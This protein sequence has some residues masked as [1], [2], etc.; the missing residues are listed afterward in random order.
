QLTLIAT[1]GAGARFEQWTGDVQGTSNITTVTMDT[2]KSVAAVFAPLPTITAIRPSAGALRGGDTV[3]IEG[4]RLDDASVVLFSGISLEIIARNSTSITVKTPLS[5]AAS[6]NPEGPVD[7]VVT[8]PLGDAVRLQ[9]F[10][11]MGQPVVGAT[12]PAKASTAGGDRILLRGRNLAIATQVLFG[13]AAGVIDEASREDTRLYVAAPAHAAGLVD[14]ELLSNMDPAVLTGAFL[15]V[16]VPQL[17]SIFPNLGS[18]AGGDIVVISGDGLEQPQSVMFGGVA[19]VVSQASDPEL[20][21]VIPAHAA[22]TVDV[23]VTTD[24]GTATLANGFNYVFSA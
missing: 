19:A 2:D 14:V 24:T 20:E 9:G 10:T 18:T 11:F 13:G 1:P 6:P 3:V 7:V 22:G 12:I 8:T 16:K 5:T 4:L 17:S 15:Y 21:V 23:S